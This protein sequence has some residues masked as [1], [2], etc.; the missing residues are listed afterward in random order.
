MEAHNRNLQKWYDRINN[1]EIKLPRFQRFEAWDKHRISSLLTTVVQGLPLGI[2]LVLEVGDR[3]KFV[4]RY[5]ATAPKSNSRVFE[6][7]LDGQ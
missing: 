5:L 1:G 4:S 3:E 2:T 7:L 6:Q